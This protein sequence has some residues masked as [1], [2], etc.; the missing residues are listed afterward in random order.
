VSY[1]ND[2]VEVAL[3]SDFR[4]WSQWASH[5]RLLARMVGVV[6]EVS[7]GNWRDQQCHW[8]GSLSG[9]APPVQADHPAQAARRTTRQAVLTGLMSKRKHA[10]ETYFQNGVRLHGAGRLQEAEQV[11]RQVL[12]AS[13]GH[14]DSLH[15]LGVLASQCGQPQS[16]LACFDQA[17]SRKPSA[18]M[19]HVNRAA[20][21]LALR[22]MDAALAGCEQ[23]IRLKRNCAEA[24]QVMGD[25]LSDLGRPHEA[26][27]A[28]REALRLKPDLPDLHNNIG[29]ALR[30]A[31][32]LEEASVALRQAVRDTPGDAQASGNLAGVLKEL[33]RLPE[34]EASYRDALRLRPD[35]P[36]QHLNLAFV[37]LLAGQFEEGW[38][39]YEW[40]FRAS[41]ALAPATQLP[42]W[43]GEAL[44]GRT[45]LIRAEQGVG[46]T[47]Q[48]CRYVS[49]AVRQGSV[50]LEVQR[51]LR[52]LM[53]GI[54]PQVIE[55]GEAVPACDLWSPLLS[56]P[57]IFGMNAPMPPY[58]A[59]DPDRVASW[60]HRIGGHGRRIGIA[61]QGNPDAPVEHGRSIPLREFLPLAQVPGIRLI[62]LQKHHGLD[63][64]ATAPEALR[65]EMLGEDFDAG[66]DAFIDTAAV[67]QSLDLIITSDTSVA[68]LAGALG[69]PVWVALQHVPDW[70]W[71]ME[72]E[73]CHW[74]PSMRLFRQAKRGDW[75]GVFARMAEQLR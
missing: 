52:H 24:Y 29:L 2:L 25:V 4:E 12:T 56:L 18:A 28:Y 55:V 3:R 39:E 11:Y 40:R 9:E 38:Q 19:F 48:F 5:H 45:L 6:R 35:D 20:A 67:M 74:Y 46:S 23:A 31:G 13:P 66:P 10:I 36:V 8:I 68:H 15:M 21:L 69:R 1:F 61:W 44:D 58:L 47:M 72:G 64:L 75:A 27:G 14:A 34:A 49:L 41:P 7:V 63:Q 33:G 32:D 16:A 65:V 37:L 73:E 51:G 70:R 42:R 43:G 62:S 54:V 53:R 60:Q 50:V 17:I 30:Q 57:R 71:L 22:Q 59:A 26:V